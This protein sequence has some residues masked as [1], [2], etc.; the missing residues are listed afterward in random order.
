MSKAQASLNNKSVMVI[1]EFH[2]LKIFIF[3][4]AF[5][6]RFLVIVLLIQY[7]EKRCGLKYSSVISLNTIGV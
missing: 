5:S 4:V 3:S 2:W 6:L 7:Y 1:F